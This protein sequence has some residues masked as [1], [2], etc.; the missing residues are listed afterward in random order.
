MIWNKKKNYNPILTEE[1]EPKEN[2]LRFIMRKIKQYHMVSL[3]IFQIDLF[4]WTLCFSTKVFGFFFCTVYLLWSIQR[5]I[6]TLAWCVWSVCVFKY[7]QNN[8]SKLLAPIHANALPSKTIGAVLI[9]CGIAW[10]SGGYC[11]PT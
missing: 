9:F 5:S 4:R 7:L 6:N 8:A 10:S 1:H 2:K 3:R 11:V